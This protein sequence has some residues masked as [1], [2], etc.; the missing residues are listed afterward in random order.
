MMDRSSLRA[1]VPIEMSSSL[2]QDQDKRT[3][4]IRNN[5][6][7]F[8]GKIGRVR[9]KNTFK[10]GKSPDDVK[11]RRRINNG[12]PDTQRTYSFKSKG[13][14][15]C[16]VQENLQSNDAYYGLSFFWQSLAI[17]PIYSTCTARLVTISIKSTSI[18]L[19]SLKIRTSNWLIAEFFSSCFVN[20]SFFSGGI[21]SWCRSKILRW[22]SRQSVKLYSFCLR[23][24]IS[25]LK[26][27]WFYPFNIGFGIFPILKRKKEAGNAFL[28]YNPIGQGYDRGHIPYIFTM[29]KSSDLLFAL[30]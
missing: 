7:V 24:S 17:F 4:N 11:V 3:L 9:K 29:I 8:I 30:C 19:F 28:V 20:F 16:F 15:G 10:R 23:C 1:T 13:R 14:N 2:F 6:Y 18:L 26:N 22:C 5:G 12:T 27:P 21:K 25:S